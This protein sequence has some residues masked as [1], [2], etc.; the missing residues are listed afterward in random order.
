MI[1]IFLNVILILKF[2]KDYSWEVQLLVDSTFFFVNF[3]IPLIFLN[4]FDI[5]PQSHL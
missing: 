3:H 4:E 1:S 5:F 2:N